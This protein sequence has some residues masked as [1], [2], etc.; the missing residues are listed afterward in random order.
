MLNLWS[1][2]ETS[3]SAFGE[4]SY[5]DAVI[6]KYPPYMLGVQNRNGKLTSNG[7]VGK[8]MLIL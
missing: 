6:L 5:G 1:R 7:E 4:A 8:N 2:A 3:P